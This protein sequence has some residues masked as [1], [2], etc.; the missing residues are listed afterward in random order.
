MTNWNIK[1]YA[2]FNKHPQKRLLT[3][4]FSGY[5]IVFYLYR[6]MLLKSKVFKM[7]KK[8]QKHYIF[9]FCSNGFCSCNIRTI[10]HIFLKTDSNALK[11]YRLSDH[12]KII[13]FS[14]TKNL[15][16]T[17]CSQF[18]SHKLLYIHYHCTSCSS[19]RSLEN[20][21]N[22]KIR[23]EYMLKV[24]SFPSFTARQVKQRW[25]DYEWENFPL[26]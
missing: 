1:L 23:Y 24:S 12:H 14:Y 4:N 18:S 22:R 10:T 13:N 16:R 8:P 11:T 6:I 15:Y 19:L 20:R 7:C 17:R 3:C 26:N 5:L 21:G 2:S 9:C 25:K